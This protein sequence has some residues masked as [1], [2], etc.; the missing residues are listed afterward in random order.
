MPQVVLIVPCY[1]EAERFDP[2]GFEALIRPDDRALLF[3]NDGSTD[4]T[5]ALIRA[6]CERFPGRAGVLSL[7]LNQ[8]KGGA[9]RL[10]LRRALQD[11]API[12]GYLDADLATPPGEV[13]RLL[14]ALARDGVAAVI[15]SRIRFL[16]TDIERSATRH[17]IGRLFATFAA[18]TL[19]VAVYDT[20]CGAKVF[21]RTPALE[22][23]LAEPFVTRWCF[24]LELLGRL[25]IG[26][27]GVAPLAVEGIRELPLARWRHR[28]GSRIGMRHV[29]AILREMAAVS[30]D[31]SGRRRRG[32][33]PG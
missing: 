17:Y 4:A 30:R 26:A 20:Q 14:D 9:V 22:S 16:G 1:N 13:S 10:G 6:F 8:G 31:L 3:V 23:A 11:G 12:V 21:R 25:L 2:E 15:G 19:R 32:P 7:P 29:F 24:D 33:A 27:P 28:P 18:F 5:G